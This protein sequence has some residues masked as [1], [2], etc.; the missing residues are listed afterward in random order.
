ML[1]GWDVLLEVSGAC[2]ED[3]PFDV[4]KGEERYVRYH[5]SLAA[6][7]VELFRWVPVDFDGHSCSVVAVD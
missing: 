4:F 1:F 3:E 6:Y 2:G 5:L 7:A